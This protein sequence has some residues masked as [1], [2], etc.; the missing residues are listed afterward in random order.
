[1]QKN[2]MIQDEFAKKKNNTIRK[3]EGAMAGY[4]NVNAP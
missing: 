4:N 3:G 1:M 2:Q